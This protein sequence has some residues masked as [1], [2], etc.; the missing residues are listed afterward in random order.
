M[1]CLPC[2]LSHLLLL[3]WTPL[4]LSISIFLICLWYNLLNF[5]TAA[6]QLQL[7]VSFSK[8]ISDS[9]GFCSF[10]VSHN[11]CIP[12]ASVSFYF[13]ALSPCPSLCPFFYFCL[14]FSLHFTASLSLLCVSSLSVHPYP[15]P[16][17][18]SVS[19]LACLLFFPI[20]LISTNTTGLITCPES[21]CLIMPHM[22]L[23]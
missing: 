12:L 21:H 9:P 17:L 20:A 18:G 11:P 19:H 15:V 10:C 23:C 6:F 3:C 2:P 22:H 7:F 5:F 13:T 1:A 16:D 4:S 14:P 8:F